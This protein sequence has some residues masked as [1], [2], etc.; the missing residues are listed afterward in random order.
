MKGII[1]H[2]EAEI[3][4]RGDAHLNAKLGLGVD[5]VEYIRQ[6]LEEV[7]D[8]NGI[9]STFEVSETGKMGISFKANVD[10]RKIR[11]MLAGD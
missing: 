7:A 6:R 9:I 3:R 5:P 11:A 10:M 4:R 1:L 2:N 8:K